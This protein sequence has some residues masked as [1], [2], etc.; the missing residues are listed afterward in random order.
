MSA[1]RTAHML[2]ARLAAWQVREPHLRAT[3]LVNLL[4]GLGWSPPATDPT[5]PHAMRAA[6]NGAGDHTAGVAAC[7]AAIQ[8]TGGTA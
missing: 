8:R 7:R 5:D 2:A 1:E 6:R 3:E 4:L